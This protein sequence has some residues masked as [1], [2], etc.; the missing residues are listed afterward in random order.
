MN[1]NLLIKFLTQRCSIEE[2]REV[3]EWISSDPA[4]AAWLFEMEQLWS[5]KHTLRFSE[6]KEIETAYKRFRE[7]GEKQKPRRLSF[8]SRHKAKLTA[9]A[10]L[11]LLVALNLWF[12]F[13]TEKPAAFTTIE[14]PAGQQANLTL[15][16]GTQVW[17]NSES[18]LTYPSYFSGKSREVELQG[19]AYFEVSRREK[20][21]FFIHA[22]LL[23][24]KVLGT[25]FNMKAYKGESAAV[26]LVKG[27]V[28]VAL[29]GSRDYIHLSPG[30]QLTYS[31]E[32]GMQV[33]RNV[34]ASA[35]SCWRTGELFFN[36][37]P[38]KEIAN[39]LQHKF[40][41]T[42]IIDDVQLANDLFSHHS[43]RKA[44]LD[45]VLGLLKGTRQLDYMKKNDTIYII[46]PLKTK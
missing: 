8:L 29:S 16:D 12:F 42:I 10:A 7:T 22:S 41:V 32:N 11:A 20:S 15:A 25:Q 31:P 13:G 33:R 14:V 39:A 43:G 30:E 1:D 6:K 36:G 46:K 18:K 24:V 2:Y 5:L 17:L 40:N 21:P 34:N 3:E 19:E 23:T 35:S 9:A 45:Q 4:H 38:L 28:D 37:Q 26:T 27:K 44:S